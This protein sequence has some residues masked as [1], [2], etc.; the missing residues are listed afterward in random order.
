MVVLRGLAAILTQEPD[1]ELVACVTCGQDAI[2]KYA[3]YQPDVTLM[4][5]QLPGMSGFDAIHAIRREA[6][7]AHILV[8]TM[9]QGS[10]DIR[11]A[12]EAGASGYLFKNTLA[13]NLLVQHHPRGARGETRACRRRSRKRS[14]RTCPVPSRGGSDAGSIANGMR[15]KEIGAALGISEETV[16]THLRSIFAKLHANDRTLALAIAI[17]RGIVHL[18]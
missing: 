12:L 18:V 16:H 8:L 17:R 9:H 11:R 15:N 5:L 7:S 4:D 13:D 2:E 3:H 10:E 14:E 6:P 1:I